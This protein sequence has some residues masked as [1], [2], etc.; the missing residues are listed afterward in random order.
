MKAGDKVK[1]TDTERHNKRPRFYP[2]AE[3]IGMVIKVIGAYYVYVQWEEGS[4]SGDDRWSCK[5]KSVQ[6]I[7]EDKQ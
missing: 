5:Q 7:E 2:P 4:T 6:L 3:T 1:F